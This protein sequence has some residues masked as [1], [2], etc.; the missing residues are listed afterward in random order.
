MFSKVELDS[1]FDEYNEITV[2]SASKLP[3]IKAV[4]LKNS[5]EEN[6]PHY[7]EFIKFQI[8]KIDLALDKIEYILDNYNQLDISIESYEL[9][10]MEKELISLRKEY[11]SLI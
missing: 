7:I 1:I 11:G 2:S 8:N 10:G 6:V 3:E 9:N 4:D 5:K